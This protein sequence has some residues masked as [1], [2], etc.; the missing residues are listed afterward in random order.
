VLRHSDFKN[1]FKVHTD[2]SGFAIT[3]IFMQERRSIAFDNKKPTSS[4]LKWSIHEKKLFAVVHCLKV[5]RH[6]L[7]VRE[8]KF[9]ID[10]ISLKYFESKI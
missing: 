6:Y 5:W 4:Q 2:A 7:E 3:G 10:N 1:K 8:T 9:Y